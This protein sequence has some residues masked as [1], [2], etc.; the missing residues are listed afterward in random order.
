MSPRTLAFARAMRHDPT[1]PER[2]LWRALR[3]RQIHGLKFR[4]QVPLGPYI[5]DL[6]CPQ[7]ALVVEIDGMTHADTKRDVRRDDWLGAQ[8]LRVLRV[9]NADVMANLTGAL[10]EIAATSLG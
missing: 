8:G 6:Y 4:R 5:L 3:G 10:E 7:C 9:R 2:R 1:P